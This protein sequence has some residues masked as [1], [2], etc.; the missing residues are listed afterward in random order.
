MSQ[1]AGEI[2][3]GDC[4]LVGENGAVRVLTL[5]RPRLRNAIDL[6]LRI[7]LAERIEEAMTDGAVRVIVLTGAGGTFCSGGDISTMRRRPAEETRPRAEAA[8]RI[9]RAIWSGPKPVL[10]AVEGFAFGAGASLALACDQVVAAS[11][12]VFNPTFTKVGLAGDLGIFWSLSRR[13]GLARARRLLMLPRGVKGA[14]ALEM[15]LADVLAEPGAALET[16]LADAE[17][18]AAAPPLALATIKAM[19]VEGPSDPYEVLAREVDNQIRLFDTDDFAEGVAAF[20]E[21]RPPVFR[22]R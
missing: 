12:A 3:E 9:V 15:G 14:E 22:G 11:D 10:A 21:R 16:A 13:V 2:T 7:T 20:R 1:Q 4:V 17:R 6:E 5:N 19:L 18:L 8:Q